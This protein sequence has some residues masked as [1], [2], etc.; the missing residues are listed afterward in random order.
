MTGGVILRLSALSGNRADGF[1]APSLMG[2]GGECHLVWSSMLDF[3][4]T[5]FVLFCLYYQNGGE[6]TENSLAIWSR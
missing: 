2:G 3:L 1:R 6:G 4:P 5:M